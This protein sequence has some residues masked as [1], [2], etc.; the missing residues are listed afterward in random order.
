ML[1]TPRNTMMGWDVQGTFTDSQGKVNFRVNRNPIFNGSIIPSNVEI[2]HVFS[3]PLFDVRN[4]P[5]DVQELLVSEC[6]L[7][8]GKDVPPSV[9]NLTVGKCPL[10][11]GKNLSPNLF[12]LGVLDCPLFDDKNIPLNIEILSVFHCPMFTC[13]PMGLRHL[14]LTMGFS[15]EFDLR[16]YKQRQE[17]MDNMLREHLKL[18]DDVWSVVSSYV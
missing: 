17:D 4:I 3:C 7:F 18:N 5:R 12:M 10:F 11:D 14:K 2:V 13:V 8:D 6:P 1:T 16:E 15:F 9:K